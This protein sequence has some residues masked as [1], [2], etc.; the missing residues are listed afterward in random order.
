MAFRLLK[1]HGYESLLFP[2]DLHLV[3]AFESLP[4][5][6]GIVPGHRAGDSVLVQNRRSSQPVRDSVHVKVVNHSFGVVRFD[7]RERVPGSRLGV[8]QHVRHERP[9]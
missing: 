9:S 5:R 6:R 2:R 8:A 3:L 4:N 7:C 1:L